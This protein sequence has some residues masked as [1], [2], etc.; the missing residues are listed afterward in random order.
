LLDKKLYLLIK[1][2]E[3]EKDNFICDCDYVIQ[4]LYGKCHCILPKECHQANKVFIQ[5]PLIMLTEAQLQIIEQAGPELRTLQSMAEAIDAM[6]NKGMSK[7]D[8]LKDMA[9]K[10]SI[11]VNEATA[12]Y[13]AGEVYLKHFQNQ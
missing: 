5:N 6:L 3:N 2:N 8:I 7:E 12:V 9:E 4:L 1:P 11:T 13:N 10:L